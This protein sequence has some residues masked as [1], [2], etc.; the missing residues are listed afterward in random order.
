M[1]KIFI[2]IIIFS[3]AF[4]LKA[5]KNHLLANQD[6][7]TNEIKPDLLSNVFTSGKEG[8]S[9]YRIPSILTTKKGALLAFCEGRSSLSDHAKNDIVMKR[10]FD[11]GKTWGSLHII[12]E[13]GNNCLS[14]PTVVQI[15]DSGKII[16]M[17]QKYPEGFHERE[18][19]PGYT[20]DKICRT[21]IKH[22]LD[23]GSTWS[24][25][26]EITRLVKREKTATSTASGPGIGIQIKKGKYKDRIIIPFNQ[27]PHGDWRVYTVYSDDGGYNWNI[28]KI[29]PNN[30]K[31]LGNEVQVVELNDGSLL[32]N[33]RS[34]F[35][36][37]RRK[38]AFSYDG[39]ESWSPLR[40]DKKLIEP[41][42]Q[43]TILRFS[44]EKGNDKSRILFANP[45]STSDR[46]NGTIRI[47]YDE[48]KSWPVSKIVYDRS[49]AYSC[50]TK[51]D[52][53]TIGLLY[54]ADNYSKIDLAVIKIEDLEK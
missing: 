23:D 50:L 32:L 28:G 3:S 7:D 53:K 21:F 30:S 24:D 36:N 45:A 35:G 6:S 20:G 15:K 48:G 34:A 18:V 1:K 38:I 42:C 5:E 13:D 19:V 14:N 51:I 41:Q 47:S 2:I 33:S 16:L 43:A 22:S 31:G 8:Y 9:I 39:G 44:F 40:D 52:S 4:I 37:K 25:P 46:K 17:Y 12:A 29:A 49:Y 27:G 11:K 26:R 54:E 10:S